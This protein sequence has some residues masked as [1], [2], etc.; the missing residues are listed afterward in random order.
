MD[1][2]RLT[3][4]SSKGFDYDL[5]LDRAVELIC[6]SGA[7]RI[8]LQAPEGL[9]RA[10][11]A[12]AKEISRET[13]AEVMIS[14]D[15]C[16]GACDVDMALLDEVDL[17]LHLGH[18]ELGEGPGK[19]IFLEARM[20]QDLKEAVEKAVPLLRSKKVGVTTTI[21]HVHRLGQAIDVLRAQGI[22]GLV[23]PAKGRIKYPGQVLGCCYSTAR[24]LDVDEYLFIGTGWFHPLGIALATGKRVVV[25]DPVTGEVSE[26]DTEPMLRRRFGAIARATDA[27]RFAILVSKKPGQ[28]RMEMARHL[29]EMGEAKG[30]EM[31]LV[32]LDNIEPDRLLNLGAEAAV[33]TACPRVALDDA[34]KYRIP[35]LTP[36]EFEV[37][38]GE[39]RWEEYGF[40][41]ID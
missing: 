27:R 25:A 39:R 1:R 24:D 9:K 38:V 33:S 30:K 8:G 19:V 10:L 28:R 23:G 6:R 5:D 16:Y 35:V 29:K 2:A 12:I 13:G 22:E 31:F 34:A 37:L 41:E 18:A 14:G 11:P 3:A 15:P 32:Y 17:M 40:D 36:Q 7:R 4:G 20:H 26:I 21:Q